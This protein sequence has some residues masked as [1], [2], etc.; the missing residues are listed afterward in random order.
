MNSAS[1]DFSVAPRRR[2]AL[3]KVGNLMASAD[4]DILE[5][6]AQLPDV[7]VGGLGRRLAGNEAL[8]PP[9]NI[10]EAVRLGGAR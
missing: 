9:V 6:S 1:Y 10:V 8:P 4:A 7:L 5:H 2:K 3:E